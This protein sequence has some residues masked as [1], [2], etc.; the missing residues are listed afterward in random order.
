L[1]EDWLFIPT[2]SSNNNEIL[3]FIS[4]DGNM[5][6]LLDIFIDE[7]Q[8]QGTNDKDNNGEKNDTGKND[9]GKND[10]GK[11]DTGK[12]DTGKDDTGKNDTGK[13][14]TKNDTDIGD[15]ETSPPEQPIVI[16][17]LEEY[18]KDLLKA[19]ADYRYAW[20]LK[21][22]D[23]NAKGYLSKII[24][25]NADFI[26]Y[27]LFI[28]EREPKRIIRLLM[29]EKNLSPPT[30]NNKMASVPDEDVKAVNEYFTSIFFSMNLTKDMQETNKY[31]YKIGIKINMPD[32]KPMLDDTNQNILYFKHNTKAIAV[33][34]RKLGY[35]YTKDKNTLIKPLIN[36]FKE[37]NS[38]FTFKE[39]ETTINGIKSYVLEADG[40]QTTL[41][42][43]KTLILKKIF[44][45]Y[46]DELYEL[47]LLYD[48]S[49]ASLN[50]DVTN[51][52]NGVYF[53]WETKSILKKLIVYLFIPLII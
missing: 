43:K 29:V 44:I 25:K 27:G 22:F 21:R 15:S 53:E 39:S 30:G 42:P 24:D 19:K 37:K 9:T 48:K 31:R 35:K 3:R 18:L 26:Y 5:T 17:P 1:P 46:N 20:Y 33:Q 2:K 38:S 16:R 52:I 8:P 34:M 28:D 47:A 10:T 11:D 23:D 32:W 12:N 50:Q 6:G 41:F 40:Y 4:P 45:L 13:D 14:D 51:I 36:Y 7:S 49:D